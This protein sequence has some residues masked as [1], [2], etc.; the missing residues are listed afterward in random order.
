MKQKILGFFRF[1]FRHPRQQADG[2]LQHDALCNL[3]E[4]QKHTGQIPQG[5]TKRSRTE[6]I[7]HHAAKKRLKQYRANIHK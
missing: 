4:D 6:M 1:L 3:K 7:F 5:R 2:N